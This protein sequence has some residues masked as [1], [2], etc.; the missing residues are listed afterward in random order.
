[1]PFSFGLIFGFVNDMKQKFNN[2]FKIIKRAAAKYKKDDPIK[3][4]GTTAYFTVFAVAPI[5]II[6][7]SVTGLL[8]G[9]E[10]IQSKLFSELD[11]L[12]GADGTEYVKSIVQ[13]YQ[14]RDKGIAGTIIGVV[15]FLITSTTFFTI[16]QNSLNFVWRIRSK[17]KNNLVKTLKDR[18]LSFGLVL[19]LGFI[20]LVSLLIDAIMGFVRDF[21]KDIF[22]DITILLME[23]ADFILSFGIVWLI[24]AIIYKYLPDAKIKWKVTWTGAFITTVLFVIGKFLIGLFIGNTNIGVMY[25]AAGSLVIILLWVFYSSMIFFFGAEITHEYAKMYDKEIVPNEYAVEIEIN[26]VK[27]KRETTNN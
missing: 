4:A 22:E 5:V 24:F 8:L 15:I 2:Y 1:M 10:E 6:I 16:L 17:P 23:A 11:T 12:I 9:Q 14:D 25:G 21:L 27:E 13:N 7:T 18:L 26:E 20:M 19:S 3:L